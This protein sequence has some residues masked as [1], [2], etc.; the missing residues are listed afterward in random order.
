MD[1]CK[2]N[3]P[4]TAKMLMIYYAILNPNMYKAHWTDYLYQ[5]QDSP[6]KQANIV[7]ARHSIWLMTILPLTGKYLF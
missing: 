3:A 5:L 6:G 7:I 4:D 1:L 2:R